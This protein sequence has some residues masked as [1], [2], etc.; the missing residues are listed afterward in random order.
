MF[1][2]TFL[3]SDLADL[4]RIFRMVLYIIMAP[5]I[6]IVIAMSYAGVVAT[7]VAGRKRAQEGTG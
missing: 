5:V 1:I 4:P 3:M 7:G 6:V 2:V